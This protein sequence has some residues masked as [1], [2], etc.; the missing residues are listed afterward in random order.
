M[1]RSVPG[2]DVKAREVEVGDVA[3]FFRQLN[4]N[5]G[6]ALHHLKTVSNTEFAEQ[7]LKAVLIS[8][9]RKPPTVTSMP[10]SFQHFGDIDALT[11]SVQPGGFD[12]LTS[13]RSISGV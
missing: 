13:P 8:L 2:R 3:V 6:T 9:P 1:K 7:L 10:R 12:Q 5:A 11:R 4:V